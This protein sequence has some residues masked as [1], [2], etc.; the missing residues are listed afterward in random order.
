VIDPSQQDP[1]EVFKCSSGRQ[2]PD[3]IIEASGS[4]HGLQGAL[5]AAPMCGTVVTLGYYQGQATPVNLGEEWHVN[6]LTLV[7]SMGVWGCPSRY[8]PG[9]DR[10]RVS[11]T[12]LDLLASG[13]VRVDGM[14]THRYPYARM[15]EAFRLIDEHPEQVIKVLLTYPEC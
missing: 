1:A 3:V 7:S 11:R 6:R 14:I 4:Y 8:Y 10:R 13:Q 2:P 12:A 15:P 9:W 5:R